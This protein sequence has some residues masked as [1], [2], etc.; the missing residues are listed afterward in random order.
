MH[1]EWLMPIPEKS[2]IRF[3]YLGKL[4]LLWKDDGE[5]NYFPKSRPPP[6]L[7]ELMKDIWEIASVYNKENFIA[8]HLSC[9]KTLHVVQLL[10][11][12]EHIVKS[13][14]RRIR[15]DPRVVIEHE[16]SKTLLTMHA[17]WE[18]SLCCSFAI[19]PCE[20]EVIKNK[21][22]SIQQ[23]FDMMKSTYQARQLN[24]NIP[25]FYKHIIEC[26][27]LKYISGSLGEAEVEKLFAVAPKTRSC[28]IL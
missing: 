7:E 18:M 27:L 28:I 2:Y 24:M 17:G 10:E 21:A 14:M 25:S 3:L 5:G 9:S 6:T 23:M 4:K 16:F 13:M 20:R 22:I 15:K 26:I 11:G 1:N 12:E 19:S 8:G